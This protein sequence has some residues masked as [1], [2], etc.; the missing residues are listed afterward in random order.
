VT[1]A[2]AKAKG[3]E[4]E[5]VIVEYLRQW[6]PVIERRRLNGSDDQGDISGLPGVCL[7]VKSGAKLSIPK[8]LGELEV[9]TRNAHA[10]WGALLVRLKGKPKAEDYI[11]IL[12][13]PTLVQLMVEA[14]WLPEP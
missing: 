5:K 4:T 14:G 1:P 12:P 11:A 6:S 3:R 8:W 7:E 9:E 13:V 2:Q 10:V